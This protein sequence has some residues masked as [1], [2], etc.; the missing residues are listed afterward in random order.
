MNKFILLTLLIVGAY[1]AEYEKDGDL[2]VLNGDNYK[3]AIEEHPLIFIKFYADWCGHCQEL[4]PKWAKWAAKLV[5]AE[6]PVQLAKLDADTHQEA[7][8]EYNVIFSPYTF[9]PYI[10]QTQKS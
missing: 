3:Q 7:G 10:S 4:A 6:V 2:L 5:N 9:F 1:S 8:N